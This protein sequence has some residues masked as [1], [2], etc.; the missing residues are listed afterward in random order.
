MK[1]SRFSEEQIAYA[2]QLAESGTPVV[3]VCRKI[4]VSEAAY[5]TWKKNFGT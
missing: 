1:R 4:G 5:F 3:D 2:L